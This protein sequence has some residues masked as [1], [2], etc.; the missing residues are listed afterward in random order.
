MA[1]Q[2]LNT[3]ELMSGK[4]G[5][6]F[7]EHNGAN[8]PLL[9]VANYAVTMNFASVEKQFVGNPVVNTIPTGV[10]FA[11]NLTESVVRDDVIMSPLLEDIKN[12]K[13]PVYNF[14]CKVERADGM[15]Q[16][17]ALNNAVPTGEFGIQSITPGEIFERPMNFALNSVPEYISALASQYL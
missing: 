1:K 2:V 5:C 10:S 12:G 14:Q 13:F 16:R 3:V 15:Q 9:E 4:D 17:I 6:L 7:I 11:L 8:I